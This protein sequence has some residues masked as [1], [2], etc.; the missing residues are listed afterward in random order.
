MFKLYYMVAQSS[1][2]LIY[3]NENLSMCFRFM[4]D[5]KYDESRCV[6]ISPN[7]RKITFHNNTFTVDGVVY[8]HSKYSA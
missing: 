7:N 4:Y 5:N 1:P 2:M 3:S 8:S 6:I